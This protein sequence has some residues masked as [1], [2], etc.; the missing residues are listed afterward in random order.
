MK[1]KSIGSKFIVIGCLSL[2]GIVCAIVLVRL[3]APPDRGHETISAVPTNVYKTPT[4]ATN[5]VLTKVVLPAPI[6]VAGSKE[7]GGSP[8]SAFPWFQSHPFNVTQSSG[9]F[10]W[11]AEDGKDTNVIRQLAHNELEYQRMVGENNTIYRRQLVYHPEGFA[12]LVQQALQSGQGIQQ[13]TLPAL[14]GQELQVVVTKTDFENGGEQGVLYGKLPGDP[15]SMVTV[16]F[17][18]GRE[19]FT[20][21]SH[22]NQTYLQAEAREPGE[23]LVKKIDPNTYG[24]GVCGNQ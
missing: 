11:T 10:A 12:V 5:P 18:N 14:D 20:V 6:P 2:A 9:G 24:A 21:I 3:I 1:Q 8:L 16:A 23:I 19:A 7:N 22:Q 13:L 4:P 15:T 17:V